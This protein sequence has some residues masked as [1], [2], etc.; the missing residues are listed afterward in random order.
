[1]PGQY[2][3]EQIQESKGKYSLADATPATE[4]PVSTFHG[5][6]SRNQRQAQGG[7]KRTT[8]AVEQQRRDTIPDTSNP[9]NP[10]N[11]VY[12]GVTQAGAGAQEFGR[13]DY[14]QGLSDMMRGI[15]TT[16]ATFTIPLAAT[17]AP[18]A[19][20]LG[21]GGGWTGGKV[22]G[23]AARAL[24]ASEGQA[25]LAED[26]GGMIGG[27]AGAMA[28][29]GVR[30]GAD[31]VKTNA[32]SMM[33]KAGD[34]ASDPLV[35][36]AVGIVS[37][38]AGKVLDTIATAR[39]VADAVA[40]VRAAKAPVS[41]PSAPAIVDNAAPVVTPP[42]IDTPAS[43]SNPNIDEL[44]AP[45]RAKLEDSGALT[46]GQNLGEAKGGT[47]LKRF[48]GDDSPVIDSYQRKSGAPG[49]PANPSMITRGVNSASKAAMQRVLSGNSVLSNNPDALQA[50]I[51]LAE[52]LGAG[53]T[54]IGKIM[55]GKK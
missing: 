27:T 19:T 54:K 40:K 30:A 43:P 50:A 23:G 29:P 38:R 42:I 33:T 47:Y 3:L 9:L 35:R 36:N 25:N 4:L 55:K 1:M 15:G 20:L 26:I 32:S 11:Y 2:S 49:A 46:P 48:S 52:A 21:F 5:N 12:N 37:P 7:G 14:T 18:L 22:A 34:M 53:K 28:A 8:P 10:V 41:A 45:L 17:T 31:F 16:A 6:P 51:D 13:G 44:L 24:G 39:D